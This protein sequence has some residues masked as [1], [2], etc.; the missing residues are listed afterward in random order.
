MIEGDSSSGLLY[1]I[2][3][4]PVEANGTADRKVQAYNYRITLTDRPG[5]R[6]EITKP[7]HYDPQRYE[8]LLRLKQRQPWAVASRCFH[9]ERNAERQDGHK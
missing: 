6:V 3:P 2:S 9:L 1:G 7:D 8:L 5:N 4:E